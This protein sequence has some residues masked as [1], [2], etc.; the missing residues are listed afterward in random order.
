MQLVETINWHWRIVYL[1]FFVTPDSTKDFHGNHLGK[2]S[3]H[4][5]CAH[6]LETI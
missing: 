2:N 1:F 4:R 5:E 3:K 6:G